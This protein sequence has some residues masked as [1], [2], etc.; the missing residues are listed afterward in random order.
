MFSCAI[1]IHD[2]QAFCTIKSDSFHL[3]RVSQHRTHSP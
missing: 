3:T 1:A 2:F